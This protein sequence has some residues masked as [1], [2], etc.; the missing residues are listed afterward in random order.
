[1]KYNTFFTFNS[2]KTTK[3]KVLMIGP[4]ES[5]IGGI[6]ELIKNIKPFLEKKVN[7]RYLDTVKRRQLSKSGKLTLQNFILALIQYCH[8]SYIILRF[9]PHILHI[10]TSQGIAWIKD[11]FY[12]LV[13]KCFRKYIVLHVHA[14]DFKELNF[15]QSS[16]THKYS[17]KIMGLA[18]TIIALS[19]EWK[20]QLSQL[21]PKNHIFLLKNCINISAFSPHIFHT[22]INALFL[23][24]VGPRKGVFDLIEAIGRLKSK[25]YFIS[26]WIAGYEERKGDLLAAKSLI[27]KNHVN[28]SVKLLGSVY[29]N[30]KKKLLRHS[31]LFILPSYNEGLPMALLEAMASGTAVV[32]TSVGGI[33]AIIKD[34]YNG[35]IVTPGDIEAL[36]RKLAILCSNPSLRE[37]M[38]HRCRQL[39]LDELDVNPYIDR[40]FTLYNS[41]TS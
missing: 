22:N 26:L 30:F 9:R 37:T 18:D 29:G 13:G 4:G 33:P 25:G 20:T 10:H 3:I 36:V 21:V 6:S 39:V 19:P 31:N 23:G 17:K 14:A 35:F 28:D 38:G 12:V 16:I 34:G 32:S 40:L 5:I 1:M 41:Y 8:F 7:L 15:K 24:S 27:N 11:T 2:M